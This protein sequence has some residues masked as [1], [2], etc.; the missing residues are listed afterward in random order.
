M[1][2]SSLSVARYL[3]CF[4]GSV[5]TRKNRWTLRHGVCATANRTTTANRSGLCASEPSGG[6][7]FRH[8]SDELVGLRRVCVERLRYCQACVMRSVSVRSEA[9]NSRVPGCPEPDP[10]RMI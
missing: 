2:N 9:H 10:P 7:A 3:P 6:R 1:R 8:F 5:W 4:G